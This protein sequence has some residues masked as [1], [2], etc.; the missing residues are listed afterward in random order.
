M[1]KK[2]FYSVGVSVNLVLLLWKIVW[3]FFRKVKIE[4]LYGLVIRLLGIY[5]KERKL[6][7]RR[8]IWFLFLRLL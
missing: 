2:I 7:C 6:V 4:L 3:K 1:W 5:L 8:N